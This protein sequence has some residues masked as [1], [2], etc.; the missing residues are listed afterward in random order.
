M[1]VGWPNRGSTFRET[2]KPNSHCGK[3]NSTLEEE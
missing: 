2:F 3:I 1:F